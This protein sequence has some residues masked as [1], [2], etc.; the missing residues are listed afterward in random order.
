MKND[1]LFVFL[2]SVPADIENIEKSKYPE[3]DIAIYNMVKDLPYVSQYIEG[4][5]FRL[6]YHYFKSYKEA[7]IKLGNLAQEH[8][9]LV[10]IIPT[11]NHSIAHMVI[12]IGSRR[13][14]V[15]DNKSAFYCMMNDK[16]ENTETV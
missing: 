6:H 10:N 12:Q 15:Y 14:Y 4:D 13:G 2:I 16:L 9:D 3:Q 1:S 11:R 8:E 7:V 5:L